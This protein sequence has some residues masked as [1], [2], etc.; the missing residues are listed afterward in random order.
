MKV[1]GATPKIQGFLALGTSYSSGF[2]KSNA[3]I[4]LKREHNK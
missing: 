2:F 1:I 4:W 3:V